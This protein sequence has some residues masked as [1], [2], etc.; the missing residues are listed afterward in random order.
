M[1]AIIFQ[2]DTHDSIWKVQA[3]E[4]PQNILRAYSSE[5]LNLMRG[6]VQRLGLFAWRGDL[7]AISTAQQ[8]VRPRSP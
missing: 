2:V 6:S 1:A 5:G 8:I 7:W 4:F 3:Q